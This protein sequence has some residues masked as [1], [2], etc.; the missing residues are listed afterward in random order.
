MLTSVS[1]IP[2]F[3]AKAPVDNAR[4]D[5]LGILAVFGYKVHA[6]PPP[7][8]PRGGTRMNFPLTIRHSSPQVQYAASMRPVPTKA[9]PAG[10]RD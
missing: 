9:N 3:K 10:R 4:D 5:T 8:S 1:Y 7:Y 6:A 2:S